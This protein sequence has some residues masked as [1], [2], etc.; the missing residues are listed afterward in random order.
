[1]LQWFIQLKS[2]VENMY[3]FGRVTIVYH[4]G[5]LDFRGTNHMNID[6]LAS[7]SLK[8]LSSDSGMVTHAHPNDRYLGNILFTRDLQICPLIFHPLQD[9]NSGLTI[10]PGH[11]VIYEEVAQ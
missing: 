1:M 11:K 9:T 7:Q 4:A 6:I 10:Q 5:N 8:H 2:I 3:R